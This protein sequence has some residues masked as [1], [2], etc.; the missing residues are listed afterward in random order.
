MRLIKLDIQ[1]FL[2]IE[3]Y[4]HTF[5]PGMHFIAGKNW[6]MGADE[7]ESNGAGKSSIFEAIQWCLFGTLSR[8]RLPADDVV[9]NVIGQNC[10]VMLT[11]EH[12]GKTYIVLRT[13]K[14]EEYGNGLQYWIDG[15][16]QTQHRN[17]DTKAELL[18]D[19]PIT[20][21]IF[22]YAV[23]VGQ[24]MPD[25][26][27][28]L[29]EPEKHDLICQIANVSVFDIA[30]ARSK[31]SLKKIEIEAK[32]IEGTVQNLREQ[33]VVLDADVAVHA[34]NLRMEE[35]TQGP[36]LEEVKK[37][38]VHLEAQV[39]KIEKDVANLVAEIATIDQAR[40]EQMKVVT[41]RTEDAS[42]GRIEIQARQGD[43]QHRYNDL[44]SLKGQIDM[45][46]R[47]AKEASENPDKC[48]LC[49][50]IPD[51]NAGADC[52]N[53][54]EY[55]AELMEQRA[56]LMTLYTARSDEY[57]PLQE[58]FSQWERY[59][60]DTTA[61]A[62]KEQE[63]VN[64]KA[65]HTV[66]LQQH[67]EMMRTQQTT[68]RVDKEKL[69][70]RIQEKEKKLAVLRT[71]IRQSEEAV[72]KVAEAMEQKVA[73]LAEKENSARHWKYW[74]V[75]IPNL[76]AAAISKLLTYINHRIDHYMQI[77]SSGAMGMELYQKA[78]GQGSKIQVDLRTPGGTYVAS[79]GG[80]R[81]RVDLAVFLGLFDLLQMSSGIHF[82][83]LVCDEI[84]DGLSP[85]GVRKLASVFR[86]KADEG[87][88]VYVISHNP[89][90][91]QVCQFDTVQTIERRGGRANLVNSEEPAHV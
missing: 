18:D 25:R 39:Q 87:M 12:E 62:E 44:V 34:D 43:I 52:Q 59:V 9:N 54:R 70:N 32:V 71:M 73:L 45:L 85:A 67:V 76:R 82:N 37:V 33:K 50:K 60:V 80:E 5:R 11:Y 36:N 27:L 77:M 19:L 2:S 13:R 26:F 88:A 58:T 84:M 63:Q 30:Q 16:P 14:D 53:L 35:Q 61:A 28:D 89:A 51:F 78:H 56:H 17:P 75:S 65:H 7:D 4:S 83:V 31:D 55:L 40:E 3:R 74:V 38:E 22:R 6:D 72:A 8:G 24:N 29:S 46:D 49:K 41:A 91:Q 23:Q 86:A 79:S 48:V 57:A 81:R 1:H 15:V 64:A 90:V 69:S 68:F 66:E 20:E 10:R 42:K 21:K 47:D